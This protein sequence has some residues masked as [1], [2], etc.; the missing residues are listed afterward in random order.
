MK[1]LAI[2]SSSRKDGD[3]AILI[4]TVFSDSQT[5]DLYLPETGTGPFLLIVFLIWYC[6]VCGLPAICAAGYDNGL[7]WRK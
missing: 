1:V 4:N 6:T 5:L 2:N 7:V 3:T